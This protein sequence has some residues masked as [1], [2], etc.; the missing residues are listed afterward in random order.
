MRLY[1]RIHTFACVYTPFQPAAEPNTPRDL[2]TLQRDINTAT[3]GISNARCVPARIHASYTRVVIDTRAE[4]PLS[5]IDT[6]WCS[7]CT[8]G[9]KSI[10]APSTRVMPHVRL[11]YRTRVIIAENNNTQFRTFGY[12]TPRGQ[13]KINQFPGNRVYCV[14]GTLDTSF[15]DYRDFVVFTRLDSYKLL[16]ARALQRSRFA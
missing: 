1:Q 8:H 3:T 6:R 4:Y 10:K 14:D 15:P 12:R 5:L 7:E 11:T 2:N 9:F 13:I 16:C